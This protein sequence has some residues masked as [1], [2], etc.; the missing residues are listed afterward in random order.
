MDFEHADCL[1]WLCGEAIGHEQDGETLMGASPVRSASGD[2]ADGW[3]FLTNDGP[4]PPLFAPLGAGGRR[5]I[6]AP[7][8]F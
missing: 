1:S 7:G 3:T 6:P 4:V 8:S 5:G 2:P